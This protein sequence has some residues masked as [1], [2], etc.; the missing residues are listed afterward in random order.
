MSPE[1]LPAV[2]PPSPASPGSHGWCQA[3]RA[4]PHPGPPE[5]KIKAAVFQE[6]KGKRREAQPP[7]R[8]LLEAVLSRCG[9]WNEG[10]LGAVGAPVF[11]CLWGF[12]TRRPVKDLNPDP[13]SGMPPS[14][15]EGWGRLRSVAP[16]APVPTE[17]LPP[18]GGVPRVRVSVRAPSACLWRASEGQPLPFCPPVWLAPPWVRRWGNQGRHRLQGKALVHGPVG[19]DQ[20][21]CFMRA[22]KAFTQTQNV[23]SQL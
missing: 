3:P 19:G 8:R 15:S 13:C 2:L 21:L 23:T 10:R 9:C 22:L 14:Y 5:R 20:T 12:Q 17:L 7:P 16:V 4:P 6:N 18:S 11:P 1:L